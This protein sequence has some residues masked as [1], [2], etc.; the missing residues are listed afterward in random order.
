MLCCLVNPVTVSRLLPSFILF[1]TLV[2]LFISMRAS[3]LEFKEGEWEFSVRQGIKGMPSAIGV[4]V[5]RECLSQEHPIPT[6]Y[7]QAQSCDVLEQHAVYRTLRYKLSCYTEHGTITNEGKIHF[8]DMEVKGDSKS[9]FGDVAGRN[10]VVRY[11]FEAKRLGNC[12]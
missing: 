4:T 1:I 9:N 3:A 11:K 2:S 5:W 7:L 10:M 8:G 12:H 6:L